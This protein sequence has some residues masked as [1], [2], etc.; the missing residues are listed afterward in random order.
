M[1]R[2]VRHTKIISGHHASEKQDKR[3]WHSRFR[4]R[5]RT[6]LSSGRDADVYPKDVSNPYEMAKD[7][8]GYYAEATDRDMRK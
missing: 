1:T 5:V 6:L 2:S 3:I 4:A 8:T 7:G